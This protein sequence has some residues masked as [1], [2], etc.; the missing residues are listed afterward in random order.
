MKFWSKI[1]IILF[2]VY[3]SYWAY[4]K[5]YTKDILDFIKPSEKLISLREINENYQELLNKEIKIK[6]ELKNIH[7]DP[8]YLL[9]DSDGY[10]IIIKVNESGRIYYFDSNYKV[11]G[12]VKYDFWGYSQINKAI[13]IETT[14]PLEKLN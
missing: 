9:R 8:W 1:I 14:K 10:E 2:I 5:E 7:L 12:I 11:I 13:Y 4:S 3:V 6:G